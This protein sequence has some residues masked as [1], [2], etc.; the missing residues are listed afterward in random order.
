MKGNRGDVLQK[1][2]RMQESSVLAIVI[3]YVII[4]TCVN[5]AF[6][7]SNNIINVLRSTGYTLIPA[8]GMTLVFICGGLDISIGSTLALGSTVSALFASNGMNPVVALC[9]GCIAGLIVG[10]FNGFFIVKLGIPSLIVTLGTQYAGRGIVYILTKGVAVYPLPKEF[11]A[12]EQT[13]V[14]GVI[15][16]IVVVAIVLS[17]V[18]HVVMTRTTFGRSLYAVGGNSESARLAGIRCSG[19]SM[20]AYVFTGVLAALTGVMMAARLG[21]GQASSGEG[22]EMT[23]IAACVIGGTSVTG[24]NGT[25]FGTVLGALFMS[26]LENSMTLMKVSVYWQKVVIGMLLIAACILDIYKR[27]AAMRADLN[28]MEKKT[29][30]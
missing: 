15:P 2:W 17:I 16:M 20:A 30:E 23:V 25:I 9:C 21:S 11:Q 8:L 7:S 5:G 4:V 13:E 10:V 28:S 27:K 14:F 29:K 1:F 19:T 26:I 3:A 24:G 6:M 18:F 12:I 22:L